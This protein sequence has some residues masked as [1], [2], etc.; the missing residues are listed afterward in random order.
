MSEINLRAY[1]AGRGLRRSL[2]RERIAETFLSQKGHLS[3]EELLALVRRQDKKIGLT[4]VYRTLKLLT[5][6]GLAVERKFHQK[7][8]TFEPL[9]PDRHHDHLICLGCGAVSEFAN[10]NIEALQEEVAATHRFTVTHHVLDLY[11]YCRR[12]AGKI[13]PRKKKA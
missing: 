12:C 8:S 4:T 13:S 3:A 7:G 11:G 5:D 6:C 10:P 2:R 9:F 1:W